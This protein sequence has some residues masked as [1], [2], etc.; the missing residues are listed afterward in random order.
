[1]KKELLFPLVLL[2]PAGFAAVTADISVIGQILPPSCS[3]SWAGGTNGTFALGSISQGDLNKTTTTTLPETTTQIM[4]IGCSGPT[5]VGFK[6]IDNELPTLP[7]G[8]YSLSTDSAGNPIGSFQIVA[9]D[10]QAVVD[11]GSGQLKYTQ[12]NGV[13]WQNGSTNNSIINS[14]AA[15]TAIYGFGAPSAANTPLPPITDMSV[16]LAVRPVIAARDNLDLSTAI[17]VNG[18]VTFELIYM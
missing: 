2:S 16:P 14:Y 13:S 6:T 1:M 3:I 8:S 4:A 15:S 11:G 10:A 7:T 12:N 5:V 18:S 17:T 9:K